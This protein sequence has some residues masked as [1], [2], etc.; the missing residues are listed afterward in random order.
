MVV[1]F[2][3]LARLKIELQRH[4]IAH[5]LN[6]GLDRRLREHRPAKIGVENRAAQVEQWPRPGA[7]HALETDATFYRDAI[8][9]RNSGFALL[10]RG[11]RDLDRRTDRVG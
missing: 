8:C 10:K 4:G 7:V 2:A 3:P 11:P 6:G 9:G 1:P 5:G